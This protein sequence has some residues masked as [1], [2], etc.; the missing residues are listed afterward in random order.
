MTGRRYL[1]LVLACVAAGIMIFALS[2]RDRTPAPAPVAEDS[3][4][5]PALEETAAA[6]ILV[7]HAGSRPPVEGVTR[8]RAEARERA[9]RIGAEVKAHRRPFAELARMYSDAP[10]AERNG[11][12]MG[13]F[14]RGELPLPL[15]VPLFALREN[16]ID[17]D[18]ETRTGYHVLMRLPVRRAVARH[19]LVAWAGARMAVAGVTRTRE[20]AELLADEVL[21]IAATGEVDFCNLAARFSDDPENR[22]DCGLLGVIEPADLPPDLEEELFALSPGEISTRRIESEYGFHIL[23]RD[24]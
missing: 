8:T 1:L 24:E 7:A 16:A 23:M 6:H 10:S 3:S 4:V 17:P 22:F 15:E 12:Y 14:R 9:L 20:Q 5:D 2:G 21:S 13:I 19:I 18:V 11:G